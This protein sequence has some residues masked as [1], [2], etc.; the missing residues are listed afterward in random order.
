VE[1][2]DCDV[3]DGVRDNGQTYDSVVQQQEKL[4]FWEI[5]ILSISVI[6]NNNDSHMSAQIQGMLADVLSTL[7]SI[8]SQKAKANENLGAKVMKET[9]EQETDRQVVKLL[10][11]G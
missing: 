11:E 10:E 1:V 6:N 2:V 8:Q 7:S 3:S 5:L 9:R 4:L